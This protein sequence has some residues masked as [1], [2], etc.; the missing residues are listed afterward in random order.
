MDS[1]TLGILAMELGAGRAA[2]GD[3]LDLGVGI[4]VHAGVGQW[5]EQGQKLL[6]LH[7]NDRPGNP[8]PKDWITL[9]PE[10][11]PPSPWLLDTVE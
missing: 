7:F 1:R 10:P 3:I 5:V 9:K 6:T 4:V 11:R 2:K 8:L